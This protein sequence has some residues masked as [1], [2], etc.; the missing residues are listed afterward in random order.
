MNEELNTIKAALLY[1]LQNGSQKIRGN[2][3]Y[4]VKALFFAQQKHLAKYLCPIY[5]DQI[6]ALKFGPV[7]SHIYD[8][9]KMARGDMKS[10]SYRLND[11]LKEVSKAIGF[12]DEMFV[13]KEDAD[14]NYL[15]PSNIACLDEA[16]D[17]VS[18]L[19][20]EDILN[21]T[22]GKEWQ[23]AY[24]SEPNKMMDN[25]AIAQEGG[26]SE[27]ELNY[28]RENICFTESSFN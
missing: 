15:S 23:R 17:E 25:I 19:S 22:H 5:N 24:S 13:P 12:E 27:D 1:V 16:I 7:P 11:G 21:M 18:K 28:L 4:I 2:V 10:N 20:F 14:I 26:A 3:Y 6:V 8:I 9:L